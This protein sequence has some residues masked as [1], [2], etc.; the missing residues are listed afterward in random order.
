[1]LHVTTETIGD[2]LQ[3]RARLMEKFGQR[4]DFR[5]ELIM[6]TKD[7]YEAMWSENAQPDSFVVESIKQVTKTD[8]CEIALVFP[9]CVVCNLSYSV[10]YYNRGEE[11]KTPEN[12]VHCS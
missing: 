3:C 10:K 4:Y 7:G 2:M 9:E 1:M 11:T 8:D 12:E 5:E 6:E